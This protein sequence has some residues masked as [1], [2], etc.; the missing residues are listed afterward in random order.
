MKYHNAFE[1]L[2]M[3][4]DMDDN[5]VLLLFTSCMQL[6]LKYMLVDGMGTSDEACPSHFQHIR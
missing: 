5:W 2:L 1:F 3:V 4:C 6:I